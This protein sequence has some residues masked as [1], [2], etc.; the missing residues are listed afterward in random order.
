MSSL[1]E[2]LWATLQ[3]LGEEEFK[4]LKWFLQQADIM[5]TIVPHVQVDPAIPVSRLEKA[6]RQDTVVQ[7]V[8]AYGLYEALQVT[9]KVLMKIN[10]NDLAEQLFHV[11]SAP[12]GLLI[13]IIIRTRC[14]L[15][16]L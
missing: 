7:M 2:R 10:R 3:D 16:D 12:K 8:Q 15:T 6:D 5:H 4:R 13:I 11:T 9:Q 1:K 14:C